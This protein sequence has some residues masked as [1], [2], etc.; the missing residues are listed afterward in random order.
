MF[1]PVISWYDLSYTQDETKM[2]ARDSTPG[3]TT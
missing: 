3:K 1:S 2:D